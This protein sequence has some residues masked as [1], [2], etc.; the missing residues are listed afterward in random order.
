MFVLLLGSLWQLGFYLLIW[1]LCSYVTKAGEWKLGG[2]ELC[3]NLNEADAPIKQVKHV[4]LHR[5][6]S[7]S[8]LRVLLGCF[9]SSSVAFQRPDLLPRSY[10]SPEY[11]RGSWE[12]LAGLPPSAL[13]IWMMGE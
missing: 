4:L 5:S 3:S 8:F 13:D 7:F 1:F 2:L 11:D 6:L 12:A 9:R 10:R